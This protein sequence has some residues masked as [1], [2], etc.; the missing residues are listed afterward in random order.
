MIQRIQTVYL[1]LAAILMIL[2]MFLPLANYNSP[3]AE[4]V[5]FAKGITDA[6]NGKVLYETS[7][8]IFLIGFITLLLVADIF[9]YNRR[10]TQIKIGGGVVLLIAILVIL[11]VYY[12]DDAK[13]L[14][15][16]EELL[17]TYKIPAFFPVISLIL[18]LLANRAIRKDE[19]LVRSADRI[20]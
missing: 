2:T 18:I 6:S 12:S 14:I 1:I 11:A 8:L 19:R 9:M 3:D 4:F 17:T 15:A 20:R 16:S 10:I 5:F 7:S 13:E